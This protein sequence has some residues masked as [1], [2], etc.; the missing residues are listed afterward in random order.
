MNSGDYFLNRPKT[1][2]PPLPVIEAKVV[3]ENGNSLPTGQVG[4]LLVLG[5]NNVRGY[6]NKP[7]GHR[8]G[9]SLEGW[10]RTGDLATL[11]EAGFIAIVDRAKDMV[12]RGGEN[13]YCAEVEAALF[14]HPA[15]KECAVFAVPHDRFGEVPGGRGGLQV[16]RVRERRR[17]TQARRRANRILQGAGEL[18][19]PGRG[20]APQREREIPET[21]AERAAARPLGHLS[22]WFGGGGRQ[23]G[24][25]RSSPLHR[26]SHEQDLLRWIR[27]PRAS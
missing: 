4:E 1:V 26:E 22:A 3:D 6:L 7:R 9:L 13:I 15:V 12:L 16:G 24:S 18:L 8:R 25:L 5:P 20:S 27:A 11:D 2:G 19:V 17:S 10:F 14:D 23:P 21:S